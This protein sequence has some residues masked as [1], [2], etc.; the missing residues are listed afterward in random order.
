VGVDLQA[1][2]KEHE[3]NAKFAATA[4]GEVL[5][6]PQ[7]EKDYNQ[8]ENDV[9][10]SRRPSVGIQVDTSSVVLAIPSLPGIADW[11]ALQSSGCDER[12][13]VQYAKYYGD[14]DR[15]SKV[16]VGENAE[17]KQQDGDLGDCD[18]RKI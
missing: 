16:L 11:N 2:T 7:R 1:T 5:Q 17:V 15:A 6:L 12:N 18:R 13:D 4:H 9:D 3:H 8:I 10:S 14:V